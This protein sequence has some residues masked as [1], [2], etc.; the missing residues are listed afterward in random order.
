MEPKE[1]T[2]PAGNQENAPASP[3]G[4]GIGEIPLFPLDLVLFPFVPQA[5][6]IFEERY[7]QM[8]AQCVRDSVPFG[9]VLATGKNPD[10]SVQTSPIGCLA[11][12]VRVERLP[13]G[14]MNIEV[15]GE[16]RFRL[17]DTHEQMPYR[18]GL[19][20]TVDDAPYEPALVADLVFD[21]EA[22]LRDFL[23][24]KL[25]LTEQA[26]CE[27]HLPDDPEHLGFLAA[28]ILP[29]END[30]KQDLLATTNAPA[31]LAFLRD[32]FREEIAR[33]QEAAEQEARA[34]QWEPLELSRYDE[35]RSAN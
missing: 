35:F 25:G 5:L 20:E 22:V 31:R 24:R 1:P 12:I 29:V 34:L 27:F 30:E 6:H 15:V 7:K 33:L 14:R 9:M 16:G 28:W 2:Y 17:L 32:K 4:R 23:A 8:I 3:A 21:V 19:T 11:R 10:G 13:E 26:A 18:V